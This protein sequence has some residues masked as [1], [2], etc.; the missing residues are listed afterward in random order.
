MKKFLNSIPMPALAIAALFLALAPFMQEPHLLEK[1]KMLLDG[2]L[3]KPIDIF[4]FFMH[5]TPLALLVLKLFFMF[6]DKES[7]SINKAD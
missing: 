1:S 2:N 7:N 5:G 6:S 3:T 4:D